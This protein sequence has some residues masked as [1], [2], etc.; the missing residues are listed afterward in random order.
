MNERIAHLKEIYEKA[1]T[2][3]VRTN[4]KDY[5]IENH[6]IQYIFGDLNFRINLD[7][8]FCRKSANENNL[9]TLIAE[10]Q[11]NKLFLTPAVILTKQTFGG[12]IQWPLLP[13]FMHGFEEAIIKFKP[14]YK[15]DKNSNTYDTSKKNRIPGY[16]DRILWKSDNRVICHLYD[17]SQ[18]A[19][20][21]D[22]RPVFGIYEIIVST[23][24]DSKR[25][26]I[27]DKLYERVRRLP[28][29]K[30]LIFYI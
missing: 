3:D 26:H 4:K 22:H 8:A 12:N 18:D 23:V 11:L 6:D 28:T 17:S 30:I 29:S 1:F 2:N 27:E 24:D 7:N 10:D 16:C 9:K 13:G 19:L 21:S 25:K 14:T 5:L 15:F 20:L